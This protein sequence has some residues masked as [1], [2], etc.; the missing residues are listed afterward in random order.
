M[1]EDVP[2]LIKD[3]YWD[4]IDVQIPY[5][6]ASK[7]YQKQEPMGSAEEIEYVTSSEFCSLFLRCGMLKKT[8]FV[9][10]FSSFLGNRSEVSMC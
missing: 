6:D 7:Q 3:Q 5:T 9:V 1:H 10:K 4:T 8:C 2:E